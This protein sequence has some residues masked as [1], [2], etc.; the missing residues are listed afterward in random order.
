MRTFMMSVAGLAVLMIAFSGVAVAQ[1]TTT[2]DY[3][4]VSNLQAFS[5]EANF[6]SLPG[7]LRYLMFQKTS[8]WMTYG[9]ARRTVMQQ[10]GQ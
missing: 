6:M 8:Q 5:A 2:G 7:Y 4:T 1:T 9:E 10:G 3:P